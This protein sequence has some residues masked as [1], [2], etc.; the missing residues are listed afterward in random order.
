MT[1]LHICV[2]NKETRLSLQSFSAIYETRQP[3]YNIFFHLFEYRCPF[4]TPGIVLNSKS[5]FGVM[6]YIPTRCNGRRNIAG[7][8]ICVALFELNTLPRV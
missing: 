5:R 2:N 6:I 7:H 1:L 4:H 8:Q 3:L